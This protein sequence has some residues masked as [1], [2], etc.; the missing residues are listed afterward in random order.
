[1]VTIFN[2]DKKNTCLKQQIKF[3]A[4]FTI[5]WF[6]MMCAKVYFRGKLCFEKCSMSKKLSAFDWKV[7]FNLR[8]KNFYERY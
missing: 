1:M 6:V 5:S 4:Q 3:Y 2:H 7:K 8:Q